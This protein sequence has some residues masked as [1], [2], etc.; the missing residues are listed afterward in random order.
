[1]PRACGVAGVPR[2]SRNRGVQFG[3]PPV[4]PSAV[5]ADAA[6]EIRDGGGPA[7]HAQ[8]PVSRRIIADLYRGRAQFSQRDDLTDPRLGHRRV[9]SQITGLDGDRVGQRQLAALRLLQHPR[10]G[11]A[12]ERRTH[13]EHLAIEMGHRAAGLEV[14]CIHADLRVVPA[15][16]RLDAVVDRWDR[17]GRVGQD[18]FLGA[19]GEAG[20][21]QPADQHASSGQSIHRSHGTDQPATARSGWGSDLLVRYGPSTAAPNG[22]VSSRRA[23]ALTSSRVTSSISDSVSSMV[24]C[25]P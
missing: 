13:G 16:Q 23:T 15:L 7:D 10:R 8:Q 20:H 9:R 6:R 12:L 11:V 4:E 1:M 25:S 3:L 5:V 22:L 24:R 2:V 21:S 18:G 19:G 14:D 17:F